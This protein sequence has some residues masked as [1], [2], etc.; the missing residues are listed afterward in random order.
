MT[1]YQVMT[2]GTDGNAGSITSVSEQQFQNQ[3]GYLYDAQSGKLVDAAGQPYVSPYTQVPSQPGGGVS[4]V[5]AAKFGTAGYIS[6]AQD[7]AFKSHYIIDGLHSS[8]REVKDLGGVGS[9][10][11][12]QMSTNWWRT[13]TRTGEHT[14]SYVDTD[15]Y[16]NIIN[17]GIGADLGYVAQSTQTGAAAS[18]LQN[19]KSVPVVTVLQSSEGISISTQPTYQ[20]TPPQQSPPLSYFPRKSMLFKDLPGTVYQPSVSTY[21]VGGASQQVDQKLVI[22]MVPEPQDESAPSAEYDNQ[23]PDRSV[24][25]GG[26]P[27]GESDSSEP[28]DESIEGPV[29]EANAEGKGWFARLQD[30]VLGGEEGEGGSSPVE[31][32]QGDE[33]PGAEEQSPEDVTKSNMVPDVLT[34][35]TSDQ[36]LESEENIPESEHTLDELPRDEEGKRTATIEFLWN[37]KEDIGLS[38]QDVFTIGTHFYP[39][40]PAMYQQGYDLADLADLA[41]WFDGLVNGD[42]DAFDQLGSVQID[43]RPGVTGF[44]GFFSLSP[45]QQQ[46]A[47]KD[48]NKKLLE[49]DAPP[50]AI[51]LFNNGIYAKLGED[52]KGDD[53]R[54]W[55]THDGLPNALKNDWSWNASQGVKDFVT[56]KEGMALLGGGAMI[57]G[58]GIGFLAAGPA[59]AA[60]G[61]KF[62]ATAGGITSAGVILGSLEGIG[63]LPFGFTE[64]PQNFYETDFAKNARL[65]KSG[66]LG[67]PTDAEADQLYNA[68]K[69]ASDALKFNTNTDNL[70]NNKMLLDNVNQAKEA[71][72]NFLIKHAF[73]LIGQGTM[74]NHISKFDTVTA[75]IESQS[76]LY[77][78]EGAFSD[79]KQ[80]GTRAEFHNM[81]EGWKV[82]FLGEEIEGK[83]V[84]NSKSYVNRVTGGVTLI[85]PEGNRHPAKSLSLYADG[86]DAIFDVGYYIDEILKYQNMGKGKGS[87]SSPSATSGKSTIYIPPGIE[88][89]YAGIK[90][91]GGESGQ[92]Y[93]FKRVDGA[94]LRL[95]F[96]ATD[97]SK[98]PLTEYIAYPETGYNFTAINP[99]L[100]GSIT[101]TVEGLQTYLQPGQRIY[102]QDFD[103]TGY[104]DPETGLVAMP[105]PGYYNISM[106]NKDGTKETKNVYVPKGEF[107]TVTFQALPEKPKA[108]YQKDYG[109]GGG[110]GG[111]G[112]AGGK[113]GT[114]AKLPEVALIV[115]GETCR[116]AAIWQD[117]IRVYPEIG[118]SYS[119]GAGY[120]SIRIEKAGKKPWI[121]TVF[122]ITGDSITVSP[123]FEDLPVE[124]SAPPTIDED[125]EEEI[126]PIVK[127]VFIN[128]NPSG[129]K[130]LVNG[131]AVGQWTP[132]YLDL[133]EGYYKITTQKSGYSPYE[134]PCYVSEVIAWGN[135]AKELAVSRGW[136]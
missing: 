86:K 134:I 21:T 64:L 114:G 66:T 4:A 22:Q 61:A 94:P 47:I 123:A 20:S 74:D 135:Q 69:M 31:E 53:T 8:I 110:G 27:G 131:S 2:F 128:S 26:A 42:P 84:E 56:S 120:H 124:D 55:Y 117:D 109:G 75:A 82:E 126:V 116:D 115:Y 68:Y 106:V 28:E 103:I 98:K 92:S 25:P 12:I 119:I 50:E 23:K 37:N 63:Q 136:L 59:G 35:R 85:D 100:K 118:Q 52:D 108:T 72:E 46:D 93:D 104:V 97:G 18:T 49:R 41:R 39:W 29:G 40:A 54:Y 45:E 19:Q 88:T 36:T 101:E 44:N 112:N 122:C 78:K 89:E 15:R 14:F 51:V 80:K 91:S 105:G 5:E 70:S 67:K 38:D 77:S 90:I 107:T 76:G 58:I 111:G 87:G 121:K 9:S 125:L 95:T 102:W 130:V 6:A 73:V 57:A 65:E 33:E 79:P 133:P 96:K 17:R 32:G 24:L 132:C 62:G 48:F 10:K 60:V 81:R 3:F 71:Y 83:G 34:S 99:D 7:Q 1:N 30:A 113:T 129:A 43:R 127:R 13:A 11:T 16:G